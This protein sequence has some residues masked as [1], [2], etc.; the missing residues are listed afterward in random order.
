MCVREG[1]LPGDVTT[2][3]CDLLGCADDVEELRGA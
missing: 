2:E 1:S 3:I